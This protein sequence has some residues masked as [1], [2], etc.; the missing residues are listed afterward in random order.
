[1]TGAHRGPGQPLPPPLLLLNV[2]KHPAAGWR[3]WGYHGL[4]EWLG[5]EGTLKLLLSHLSINP[6][7][8]AGLCSFYCRSDNLGCPQ[9]WSPPAG[10]ERGSWAEPPGL[11]ISVLLHG[12]GC[13]SQA[14]P[15]CCHQPFPILQDVH[16]VLFLIPELLLG[17]DGRR[18]AWRVPS[19]PVSNQSLVSSHFAKGERG[20]RP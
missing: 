16:P 17:N 20:K 9:A 19:A 12:D 11:G 5:L 3:E 1:M 13:V 6:S 15:V 7:P 2:I 14:A 8:S 4:V 10:R 18:G